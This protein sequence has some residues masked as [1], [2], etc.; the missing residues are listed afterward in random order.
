MI[1]KDIGHGM[2]SMPQIVI[3]EL[4]R[5]FV[6]YTSVTETFDN[7]TQNYRRLW[8]R[9]SLDGGN[10]WG[11]FYHYAEEDYSHIFTEFLYPSCAAYSDENI[12]VLYQKDDEPGLH[13]EGPHGENLYNVA[14]IP[15]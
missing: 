4:S 3:D 12:Y 10:S 9:S 1:G 14:K 5:I 6:V 2:S 8:I 11:Q 15:R 13:F 7:G